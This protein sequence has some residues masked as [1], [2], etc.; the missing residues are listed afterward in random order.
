MK[1]NVYI[2][3]P[4]CELNY[5]QKKDKLCNVCKSELEARG[6]M[7]NE[8]DMELCPI[9]HTNFL[10]ADEQ[11]CESCREECGYDFE[12]DDDREWRRYI[13]EEEETESENEEIGENASVIDIEDD[14]IDYDDDDFLDFGKDLDGESMEGLDMDDSSFDEEED[15]EYK[16]DEYKDDFDD[17]GDDEYKDDFDDEDDKD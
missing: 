1:K 16:D 17:Y 4:R 15:D 2:R 9:C 5:I 6:D 11:I 14:H 8:L 13:S 7:Y 12:Y 10:N 3:C